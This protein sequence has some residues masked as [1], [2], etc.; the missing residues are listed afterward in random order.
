MK[1][2]FLKFLF[3][4]FVG[5]TLASCSNP[6]KMASEADL[7]TI[8]S[9]PE[10]LEVVAGKIKVNVTVNFPDKYFHPKAILE[11]VPAIEFEGKELEGDPIVFQGEKITEN[12]RTVPVTGGSYTIPMVFDYEKGME[13]SVLALHGKVIYKCHEYYIPGHYKI[14]D[15][16]NTTYMMVK[17]A[18]D[19]V[20]IADAYQ[21]VI[22]EKAESQIHFLVNSATVRPA[23]LKT[24]H[25][26]AFQEFLVNVQKDERRAITKTDVVAYA[27]PEG[28]V[29]WN[30][31]LALNRAENAAKAFKND[32]TKK[33][34]IDAPVNAIGMG[35][36][37]E[38]FQEMVR[39]SDIQDKNLIIRVLEMYSDPVVRE[40][41]IRN[42]SQ[43]YT[44]LADEVLPQ[45]RRA[46]FIT[47]IEFVNF[48]NE[49]LVDYVNNNI[50]LLDEEALLYAATLVEN[51]DEK[52]KIYNQAIK[53]YNSDRAQ[54]NI[55]VAYLNANNLSDA[56]KAINRVSDKNDYYYNTLGVIDLREAKYNEAAQNFAK[57]N[58]NEAKYNSAIID[59][60]NGDYNTAA[61]KLD[62]SGNCNEGLAMV[63]TN[64][65]DKAVKAV[66]T[67]P[68]S[69]YIKAIV[70]ARKGDTQAYNQA[71][72]EVNK[73]ESL[74][75]RAEKDIEF[76]RYNR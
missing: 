55:A 29:D 43:V 51:N 2:N 31:K 45:L 4:A 13:K 49:E 42:M 63:L 69:N 6:S 64:Q 67:C 72:V 76:A 73:N 60:L 18:G 58:L 7:V 38:G 15:G 19:L 34:P 52:I 36:D 22:Q 54:H 53:E 35:E 25:I 23:Q 27:S 62:G 61:R 37:W 21:P 24:D 30:N 68:R 70:A 14:A 9:N 59:I 50:D 39:N 44:I 33:N 48:T 71:M 1:Q 65:L 66:H 5:F 32:I 26:K 16:A 3:I 28:D 46:R 17:T 56:K 40:K 20:L 11:L 75:A 10:V 41:E 57:S 8:Q 74:K 12:Y 47:N